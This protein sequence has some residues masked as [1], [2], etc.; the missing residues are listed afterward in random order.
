VSTV[1]HPAAQA[2]PLVVERL[3]CGVLLFEFSKY[4]NRLER[5]ANN[6]PLFAR[7]DVPGNDATKY[8]ITFAPAS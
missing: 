1:P 4:K 6:P 8:V 3:S 2:T 7:A 5:S